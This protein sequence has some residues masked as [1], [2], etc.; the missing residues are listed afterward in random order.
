METSEK[1]RLLCKEKGITVQALEVELGEKRTSIAAANS[2]MKAEKLYKIAKYFNVSMESIIGKEDILLHPTSPNITPDISQTIP[3]VSPEGMELARL[4]DRLD[5]TNRGR[6]VGY[7][8]GLLIQQGA[9]VGE[10]GA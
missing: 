7:A 6:L 2:N 8:E 1:I 9:E 10:K 4:H 3:M 5:P